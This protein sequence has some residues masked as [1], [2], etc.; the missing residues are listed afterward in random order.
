MG[1]NNYPYSMTP[2]RIGGLLLKNRIVSAPSTLHSLSN[3]EPYPTDDAI[4][5]FESR[6]RAGVGMVT[7]A[8][9]K[10]GK[11]ALTDDGEHTA[12][13]VSRPNH[14]N[15]LMEL[16]ERVHYYG[17]KVSMELIGIFPRGYTV[18]DGCLVMGWFPG[19]QI[20]RKAMEEFKQGWVDA[21]QGLVEC[22]FDSVLIH[23][24]HSVPLAQFLSPLTNKR[25]DE[26]GGSTE[27]RCRYLIEILDAIRAKVGKRLLI[28][29][30]I[31]GTECEPG[32]IDLEEGIR[33]GELLQDHLDILQVSAGMANRKYMTRCHPCGFYP[34]MPNIPVAEAFKRSGRI[35]VPI[36]AMGAVE[37]L[38]AAEEILREGKADLVTLARQLIADPELIHKALDGHGADV[39]PCIKC[40]HC[41]DST[42]YGHH[43]RCS[44]NPAAGLDHCL[45]S[46]MKEPG[47]PKKVAVIGGGPGGMK[48]A[49]TACDRG[50]SV[51][52]FE[53]RGELGGALRFSDHV[54]FKYPLA[55]Y[56][57]WLIEQVEKRPIEVKLNTNA[58]PHMIKGYDAVLVSVGAEPVSPPVPGLAEIPHATMAYGQEEA[59]KGKRVAIIGGGLIGVETGLHLAQK[60]A[61]V[62]IIEMQPELCPDA[63]RTQ[64]EE[65]IEEIAAEANCAA[66]T[67]AH[68]TAV[69]PASV[70]YVKDG[71][72]QTLTVDAVYQCA[73]LRAKTEEADAFIGS[74]PIFAEIGDCVKPGTTEEATRTAWYAAMNL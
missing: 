40:M 19:H 44:V 17:A 7:V 22:G 28:E 31:S 11:D 10:T 16:A 49:I 41:H 42:V 67:G 63:S 6:A 69:R 23:A 60:G 3:G 2:A 51:T 8:G 39:T 25:T 13:D 34:P 20:T 48:A 43:F 55:K 56:K 68:C 59:L 52:L 38:D 26:Y 27:N 1:M 14:R 21:A 61:S 62:S 58:T 70:T 54:S 12:W 65:L 74:A 57:K 9:L 47:A 64:R 30:R 36:T 37:S 33:I 35:H 71:T 50:H 53:K 46:L 32:G 45:D 18:S 24:G 29:V 5:F 72:E 73:G 4:A 66:L 15:K